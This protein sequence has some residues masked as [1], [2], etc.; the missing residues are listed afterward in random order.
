MIVAGYC[1]KID[2]QAINRLRTVGPRYN[3]LESTQVSKTKHF[4]EAIRFFLNS[5]I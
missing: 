3:I 2:L 5:T 1:E 4:L